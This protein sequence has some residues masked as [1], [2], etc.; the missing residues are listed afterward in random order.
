MTGE[1]RS[2]V[3]EAIARAYTLD[4][5]DSVVNRA[6]NHTLDFYVAK[7]DRLTTVDKLIAA[8][9]LVPDDCEDLLVK[10]RVW[11]SSPELRAAIDKYYGAPDSPDP[12][13]EVMILGEPYVDR[14]IL[15]NKLR[16]VFQ[17][18][19]RRAL[20]IRGPRAAGKSYSR[21]VIELAG[22]S[23][24]IDPVFVQLKDNVLDDIVAQLINDMNLPP[25]DYRDRMAQFSTIGKGFISALRGSAKQMPVGQRWCLIFDSHDHETVPGV[26]RDFVNDL[27]R[28]V[29]TLQM[30]PI[31]MV[32][33]GYGTASGIA[34]SAATPGNVISDDILHLTPPDVD[35]FLQ[36][37]A[38]Q[39]GHPYSDSSAIFAGLAPP[40][41]H[42][43][44]AIITARLK[45]RIA[46][47]GVL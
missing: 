1:I 22:R 20:V 19:T 42:E 8:L 38:D 33:L 17:V 23:Q 31:W 11:T 26:V 24:T 39:T 41:D 43:G 7:G 32:V 14:Q 37:M 40:F 13:E 47:I 28:E 5:L 35:K 34:G 36:Q 30:L 4:Q 2:R 27:L 18:P 29:A 21:W 10:L 16:Q 6:L 3:V 46:T 25:R 15:R 9:E 45:E 44:M 12:F